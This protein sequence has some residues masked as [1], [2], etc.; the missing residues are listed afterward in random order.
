VLDFSQ[1]Y[2]L[3]LGYD[4]IVDSEQRLHCDYIYPEKIV[5]VTCKEKKSL[6]IGT[7]ISTLRPV[8]LKCDG[9][10]KWN[11]ITDISTYLG[12]ICVFKGQAYVINRAGQTITVGPDDSN[13]S[14][15]AERPESEPVVGNKKFLVESESKLLLVDIYDFLV[16]RIKVFRLDEKARKWVKL[17][18]LGDRVL[19]LGNGCSFSASASDL[20][21]SKGNCVI[22]IDDAFLN[23]N[24]KYMQYGNCVFDLDQG[25]LLPLFDRPEYFNLFWPPTEWIH[26]CCV[27]NRVCCLALFC[28][29]S[30]V[31][32][33]NLF[34]CTR[35]NRKI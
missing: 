30:V 33:D 21:V 26:K 32:L 5:A 22:F 29:V 27:P 15:V 4:Y 28:L 34:N 12:D 7:F 18:S 2:V 6:V 17:T 24:G 20:C 35:R 16:L 31:R 25:Q 9:V 1:L 11:L 8:L 13:A 3:E 23:F 14:L 10:E 19:F